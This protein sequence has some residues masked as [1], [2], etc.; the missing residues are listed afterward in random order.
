MKR[1]LPLFCILVILLASAGVALPTPR[2]PIS[3]KSSA[4]RS[5]VLSTNLGLWKAAR[6]SI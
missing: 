6:L 2:N 4:V 5:P 3:S 1:L